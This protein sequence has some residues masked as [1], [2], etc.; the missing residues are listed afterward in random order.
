MKPLIE[1]ENFQSYPILLIH[2]EVDPMT[3]FRLSEPFYT[4]LQCKERCVILEGAGRFPIEHQGVEQMKTAILDFL[5]EIA[6]DVG[7]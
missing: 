2:P 5:N 7:I 3:P 4:R 6:K 1:P